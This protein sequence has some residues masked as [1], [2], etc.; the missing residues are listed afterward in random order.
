[1]KKCNFSAIF[2]RAWY[3]AMTPKTIT[4]SFRAIGVCLFNRDAIKVPEVSK[5]IC[6]DLDTGIISYFP[7]YSQAPKRTAS[8]TGT[9]VRKTELSKSVQ[10]LP[11]HS[12]APKPTNSNARTTI[13]FSK[14]DQELFSC[15]LENG[16]D[17]NEWLLLNKNEDKIKV[18]ESS[19]EKESF[20]SECSVCNCQK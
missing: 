11:L 1:M 3:R 18:P 15:R 2:F 19:L 20:T 6:D 5:P 9:Q 17:Y 13:E 10:E 7:P 8:C 14:A 12:P 4:T 16:Y